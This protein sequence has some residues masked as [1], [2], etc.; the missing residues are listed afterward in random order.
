MTKDDDELFVHIDSTKKREGLPELDQGGVCPHCGG[1]TE[2]G[3]GMA[4]GGFGAYTYC[5]PC[6]VVVSK[7][8]TEED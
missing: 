3:F 1:P 7:T 2:D 8:T 6:G 5:E 4:G